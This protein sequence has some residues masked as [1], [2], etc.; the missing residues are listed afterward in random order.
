MKHQTYRE[1]WLPGYVYGMVRSKPAQELFEP[2]IAIDHN[3]PPSLKRDVEPAIAS[4]PA[5]RRRAMSA[6]SVTAEPATPPE[7][8]DAVAGCRCGSVPTGRTGSGRRS[9]SGSP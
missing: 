4:E 7:A 9:P 2:S 3:L 1:G 5:R 6:E 8:D